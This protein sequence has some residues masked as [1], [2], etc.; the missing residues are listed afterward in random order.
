MKAKVTVLIPLRHLGCMVVALIQGQATPCIPWQI[1]QTTNKADRT[2]TSGRFTIQSR[3][4]TDMLVV[5]TTLEHS[6]LMNGMVPALAER[7]APKTD[8][9]SRSAH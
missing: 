3:C 5:P 1:A 4:V 9:T 7:S 8:A 6:C 2:H